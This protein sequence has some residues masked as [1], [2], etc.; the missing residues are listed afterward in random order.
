[1]PSP[2]PRRSCPTRHANLRASSCDAKHTAWRYSEGPPAYSG[3][4]H[5]QIR[6]PRPGPKHKPRTTNGL[7]D[8]ISDEPLTSQNW[9]KTAPLGVPQ[10]PGN[11]V[12]TRPPLA[13]PS[14]QEHAIH[15]EVLHQP[16]VPHHILLSPHR[17]I[18][19][20][21]LTQGRRDC[22]K[23]NAAVLSSCAA[24]CTM[25]TGE[26]E[27][28]SERGQAARSSPPY[29]PRAST[30]RSSRVPGGSRVCPR[31][32]W[33]SSRTSPS[34]ALVPGFCP[35]RAAIGCALWGAAAARAM[36]ID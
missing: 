10:Q 7:D 18:L 1:M 33:C 22:V 12:A 31:R 20:L 2:S 32:A 27:G 4:D 35:R 36:A 16:V 14:L 17:C 13:L 11:A 6:P 3:S 28:A 26:R 9:K 25:T 29:G 19:H 15:R 30:N 8:V 34:L 21:L 24:S 5:P 23:R